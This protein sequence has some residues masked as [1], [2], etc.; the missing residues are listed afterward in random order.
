MLDREEIIKRCKKA[1]A[2][3][4]EFCRLIS[5]KTG[6]DFIEVIL[7]NL[8]WVIW[9]KI[10]NEENI[11]LVIK[12]LV[13]KNRNIHVLS[14]SFLWHAVAYGQLKVVRYFIEEGIDIHMV[15]AD[16]LQHAAN[17]EQLK[18]VEYLEK[19]IKKEENNEF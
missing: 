2:C 4:P 6:E 16:L 8:A 14:D 3:L 18:V 17:N 13:K 12:Y 10:L 9:Q 19:I 1:G 15:G 5:A 11:I 7:D